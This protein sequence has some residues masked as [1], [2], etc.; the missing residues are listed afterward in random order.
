MSNKSVKQSSQFVWL[1]GAEQ[2][3]NSMSKIVSLYD[4]TG[5][6]QTCNSMS[7]NSVKQNKIID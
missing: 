4:L 2:T 3:C 7:N 6:E 5:A 1:T